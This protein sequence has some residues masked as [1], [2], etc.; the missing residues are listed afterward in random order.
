M[1]SRVSDDDDRVGAVLPNAVERVDKVR[2][3][4]RGE[5]QA[6]A[7]GVELHDQYAWA[8]RDIF[9]PLNAVK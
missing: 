9:R 2:V 8:S 5:V 1:P 6:T 7:L 3:V 4:S